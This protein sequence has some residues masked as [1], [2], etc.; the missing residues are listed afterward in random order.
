MSAEVGFQS[1]YRVADVGLSMFDVDCG[2][3][4]ELI[5][6]APGPSF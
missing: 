6:I 5:Y 3:L 4:S 1:L 2:F